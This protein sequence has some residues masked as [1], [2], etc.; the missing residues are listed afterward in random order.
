M[1][2]EIRKGD[3][4]MQEMVKPGRRLWI[5]H[6]GDGVVEEGDVDAHV[7][8]CTEDDEVPRDRAEEL[9]ALDQPAK[10]RSGGSDK[11]RTGG[12]KKTGD[13]GGEGTDE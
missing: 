9:G 2:L 6:A 8:F 12:G 3:E 13:D 11:A 4:H 10:N 7:L 1:A 5:N